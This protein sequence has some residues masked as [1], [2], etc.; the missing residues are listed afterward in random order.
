MVAIKGEIL[1]TGQ[2]IP[3]MALMKDKMA[4]LTPQRPDF[5]L[6]PKV[7]WLELEELVVVTVLVVTVVF[8]SFMACSGDVKFS[9]FNILPSEDFIKLNILLDRRSKESESYQVSYSRN[10]SLQLWFFSKQIF[11]IKFT[12]GVT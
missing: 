7:G 12:L 2:T 6:A 5:I 9:I 8:T 3:Q 1:M 4:Q 11:I 10:A